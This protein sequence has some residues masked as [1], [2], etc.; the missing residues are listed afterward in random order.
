MLFIWSIFQAI[1]KAL[2]ELFHSFVRVY[3]SFIDFYVYFGALKTF[4]KVQ[5]GKVLFSRYLIQCFYEALLTCVR[6]LCF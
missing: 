1:F 6:F 5:L 4:L 3:G 2:K